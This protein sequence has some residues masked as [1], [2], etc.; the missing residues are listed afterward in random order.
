MVQC[1]KAGTCYGVWRRRY[2]VSELAR[3]ALLL[4]PP[5]STPLVACQGRSTGF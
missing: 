2:S 1:E 3:A 5:A 4:T